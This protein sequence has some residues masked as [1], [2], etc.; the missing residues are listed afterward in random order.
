LLAEQGREDVLDRSPFQRLSVSIDEQVGMVTSQPDVTRRVIEVMPDLAR[1][2][3]AE[4]YD[5]S[6]AFTFSDSDHVL[7]EIDIA[8]QQPPG[9]SE[10]QPRAIQDKHHRPHGDGRDLRGVVP[11][12]PCSP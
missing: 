2:I 4:R 11:G 8:D 5:A 12:L 9:L 6:P 1:Q 3:H 10:A 7:M